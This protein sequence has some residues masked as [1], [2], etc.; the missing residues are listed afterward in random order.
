MASAARPRR[1]SGTAVSD[2]GVIT[3]A[4]WDTAMGF[5]AADAAEFDADWAALSRPRTRPGHRGAGRLRRG[6][7]LPRTG[8]HPPSSTTPT[9]PVTDADPDDA[10]AQVAALRADGFGEQESGWLALAAAGAEQ[11]STRELLAI[12]EAAPGS[13]GVPDQPALGVI[14]DSITQ[15]RCIDRLSA[16]LAAR[17]H[18]VDRGPVPTRGRVPGR[19]A[20]GR[21]APGRGPGRARG[22]PPRHR[23]RPAARRAVR[24][25]PRTT[26][27]PGRSATP[28]SGC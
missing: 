10:A 6:R 5:A 16:F 11:V 18:A 15:L 13:L 19:A 1:G 3:A 4:E 8:L 26:W 23:G 20:P 14:A 24:P 12:A 2:P 21:G 17:R 7:S 22:R 28:T 27:R 9:T 25:L